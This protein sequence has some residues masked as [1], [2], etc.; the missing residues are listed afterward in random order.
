MRK[1]GPGETES[2]NMARVKAARV[3]SDIEIVMA[4]F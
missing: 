4:R 3:S 1:P 2:R